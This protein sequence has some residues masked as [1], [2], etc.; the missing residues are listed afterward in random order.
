MKTLQ[1]SR[2]SWHYK[3]ASFTGF[4]WASSEDQNLCSYLR[5]VLFGL[6]TALIVTAMFGVVAFV[7]AHMVLG[8]WFSILMGQWFFSEWGGAG[9]LL[10]SIGLGATFMMNLPRMIYAVV[11]R[12]KADHKK[13]DGFVVNAY[14]SWKGKYCLPVE[15]I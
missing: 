2:D 8:V 1:F 9:V 10:C 11:N 13:P 6:F 7:V 4:S 15:I 3:L 12:A 14:K 5:H